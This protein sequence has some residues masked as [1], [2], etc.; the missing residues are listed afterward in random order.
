MKFMDEE[1]QSAVHR[2]AWH[3]IPWVV[4]GTASE[5]D[6]ALVRDHAAHCEDCREELA[7]QRGMFKAMAQAD[8]H[9][10]H[11]AGPALAR[12]WDRV[13]QDDLLSSLDEP[14]P[15][16]GAP[17]A[18]SVRWTRILAAAV[19]VQAVGLTAL[20]SMLWQQRAAPGYVTLSQPPQASEPPTIR[21][22]PAPTLRLSELQALLKASGLRIVQSNED[23]SIL[24]VALS[25]QDTR[26]VADAVLRL[27]GHPGV[28]LA[29][30][31]MAGAR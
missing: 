21:L 14:V 9:P 27:K 17:R 4:N 28:L 18:G 23:G 12:F 3:V 2:Q 22:V 11:D 24:G 31:V 26:V 29:E 13:D 15:L 8:G 7:A 6:Q 19:V 20:S 25:P 30:P 1:V 10:M 16:R 5:A